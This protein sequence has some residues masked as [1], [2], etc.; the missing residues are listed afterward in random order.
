MGIDSE[1]RTIDIDTSDQV[2]QIGG[3]FDEALSTSLSI[4][5]AHVEALRRIEH[6]S[7]TSMHSSAHSIRSMDSIHT[8]LSRLEAMITSASGTHQSK[9]EIASRHTRRGSDCTERRSS[10]VE[11][12]DEWNS[13]L[14]I[15]GPR[16]KHNGG[17][18]TAQ[19]S[20]IG[21]APRQ[22][23]HDGTR[24]NIDHSSQSQRT[25]EM[26]IEHCGQPNYY[27][28][29]ADYRSSLDE[30]DDTN[31]RPMDTAAEGE[32]KSSFLYAEFSKRAE[33]RQHESPG[34]EIDCGAIHSILRQSLASIYPPEV[35]DYVSI[36]QVTTLC[37]DHIDLLD[38]RPD[39]QIS[40]IEL[41]YVDHG[42]P[43]SA[44]QPMINL[45]NRLV[46]LR[47]AIKLSREQCKQAGYSLSE[48]DKLLFPPGSRS[49]APADG[50][51]LMLGTDGGDDSSS[52]Y[53]E[54]FHSTTE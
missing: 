40:S 45:R 16:P 49:Y 32:N 51:P 25:S 39:V 48:L 29:S 53:S 20:G 42:T 27:I 6:Y 24:R 9:I 50:P 41:S 3:R 23:S 11:K 12:G 52:I 22:N 19:D 7:M 47:N 43:A 10:A 33:P 13:N 18:S 54:D 30:S 34:F 38:I 44:H 1:S 2:H 15:S 36:R 5:S 31:N 46:E 17:S 35:V 21:I 4:H 26:A 8:E 37:E 28:P 14:S